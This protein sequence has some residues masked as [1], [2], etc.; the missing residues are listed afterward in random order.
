MPVEEVLH[1]FY[2]GFLEFFETVIVVQI[3]CAETCIASGQRVVAVVDRHVQYAEQVAEALTA[4]TA[5]GTPFEAASGRLNAAD[6]AVIQSVLVSHTAL[7]ESRDDDIVVLECRHA[8]CCL[9]GL[10][11]VLPDFLRSILVDTHRAGW[12]GDIESGVGL[13]EHDGHWVGSV[14]TLAVLPADGEVMSAA[15]IVPSCNVAFLLQSGAGRAAGDLGI[16]HLLGCTEE[17]D[18]EITEFQDEGVSQFLSA[19]LGDGSGIKFLLEQ[20]AAVLVEP[21]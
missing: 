12:N 5:A 7:L 13:K 19:L 6:N 20:S 16:L 3:A 9:G 15:L 11:S 21:P 17:L 14:M 1:L 4:G 8:A 2:I 10:N 18:E